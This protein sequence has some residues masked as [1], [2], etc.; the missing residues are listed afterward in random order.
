MA[1]TDTRLWEQVELPWQLLEAAGVLSIERDADAM[2]T[3]LRLSTGGMAWS[4]E[5]PAGGQSPGVRPRTVTVRLID[6]A[7]S[8]RLA[9]HGKT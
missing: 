8:E 4:G 9:L 6:A 5:L 3:S 2:P 1:A 7:T